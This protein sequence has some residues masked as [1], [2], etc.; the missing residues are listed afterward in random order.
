MSLPDDDVLLASYQEAFDNLPPPPYRPVWSNT[1]E[2]MSGNR[3]WLWDGY[4]A[5]SCITLLTSQWKSGK[6]T[7]LSTLLARR[8]TGGTLAGRRLRPGRTAVLSEEWQNHWQQRRRTLDFGDS[9]AFFCDPIPTRRPTLGDLRNLVDSMAC[10]H[11][12]HGVDL[13]VIDPLAA[14]FPGAENLAGPTLEMLNT[15]E[16]FQGL[17]MAV[18][19]LHHPSKGRVREGQAARG[20]GALSS[21]VDIL[22]EMRHY[23][24]AADD[25]RRRVLQAWS[26]FPETPRQLVIE[27]NA[28]GTDYIAGGDVSDEEFRERW[29]E[30]RPLFE[31]APGKLTRRELRSLLP[32]G[33]GTPSDRTLYRW[34][35]RAFTEGLLLREGNG[36]KNSP[37]RYWLPAREAEWMQDPLYRMHREHEETLAELKRLD[38]WPTTRK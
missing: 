15:L 34:L 19:L 16:S 22:I 14:F 1:L 30:L 18:L 26:R 17:G 28:E 37:H 10:L 32:S 8:A 38:K 7:L 2:P 25:D 5:D 27:W 24:S 20:S 12:S 31:S 33:L 29:R 36:H 9:V 13:A 23:R 3:H 21:H 4:L 11:T 35:E 6:T